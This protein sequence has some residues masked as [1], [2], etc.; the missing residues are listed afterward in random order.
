MEQAGFTVQYAENIDDNNTFYGTINDALQLGQ[1]TGYDTM[2]FDDW[3]NARIIDAGHVQEFD[4]GNMPNVRNN[5]LD[6]EWDALHNDPGR[7][8]S[9]PW[10]LSTTGWAWNK[11]ALL[12]VCTHSTIS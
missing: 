10:Q 6:S 12:V 4:Y 8:H 9:I 5:L 3:M 7:K 11:E 2:I 1:F